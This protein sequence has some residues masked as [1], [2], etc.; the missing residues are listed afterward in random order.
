VTGI[1][2]SEKELHL[3]TYEDESNINRNFFWYVPWGEW[4]GVRLLRILGRDI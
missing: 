1:P 4:R 3:R 2:G